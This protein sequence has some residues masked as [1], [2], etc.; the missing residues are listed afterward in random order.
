MRFPKQLLS[1]NGA[2]HRKNTIFLTRE[3]AVNAIRLDLQQYE[4][5]TGL[6]C[7]LFPVVMGENAVVVSDSDH[8]RVWVK[9]AARG[10]MRQVSSDALADIIFRRLDP[11]STSIDRLAEL[12]SRVFKEP[13]VAGFDRDTKREGVWLETGMEGYTC[14]QCGQ[15]CLMLDYHL[16]CTANDY[17]RWQ[18]LGRDDILKWVRCLQPDKRAAVYRIWFEPGTEGPARVCPFLQK[19]SGGEKRVCRIHAVKP[20]ICRQYPFTRKHALMTGCRGFRKE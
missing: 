4:S 20:E 10:P 19:V 14:R 6:L 16:E 13:A 2:M 7:E 9:Q 3:E 8:H 11:E 1:L 5:Q 18:D 12:C 15:C 17:Q